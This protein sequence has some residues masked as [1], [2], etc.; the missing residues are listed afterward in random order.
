M[1]SHSLLHLY[2]VSLVEFQAVA[3]VALLKIEFAQG[4]ATSLGIALAIAVDINGHVHGLAERTLGRLTP[5][6]CH[7]GVRRLWGVV[8]L[9]ICLVRGA[10]SIY[11]SSVY[12]K[13]RI[14]QDD[15]FAV[16]ACDTQSIFT[17]YWVVRPIFSP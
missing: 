13:Q 3:I 9:Q 11:F 6:P 12:D 15:L 17:K 16:F 5:G 10:G 2:K 14:G 1:Q 7:S 4:I 8:L